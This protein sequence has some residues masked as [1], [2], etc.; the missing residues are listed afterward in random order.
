LT[1]R[2]RAAVKASLLIANP[3]PPSQYDD[4]LHPLHAR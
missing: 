4:A 2:Y 3:A 1:A